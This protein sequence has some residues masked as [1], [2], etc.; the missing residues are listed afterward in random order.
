MQALD[1]FFKG[2]LAALLALILTYFILEPAPTALSYGSLLGWSGLIGILAVLVQGFRQIDKQSRSLDRD[3][4]TARYELGLKRWGG[5]H[6]ALSIAVTVLIL[7]HAVFFF[8]SLWAVSIAIWFGVVGF[9]ALLILNASGL[10]T[11][12]K[13]KSRE[14]GA[15]KRFHVILMLFVLAL[16]ILHIELVIGPMFVHSVLGGAVII[17]AVIFVVFVSVP[18]AVPTVGRRNTNSS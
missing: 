12:S 11:E 13:R 8:S 18:I 6:T 14:F 9:M 10:L 15:L 3:G 17:L 7:V 4:T 1:W 16:S 5:I 2:G